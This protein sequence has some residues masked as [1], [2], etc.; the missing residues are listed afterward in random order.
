MMT[1]EELDEAKEYAS[2]YS[3]SRLSKALVHIDYLRVELKTA[4]ECINHRH[5]EISTLTSERNRVAAELD[6]ARAALSDVNEVCEYERERR[7]KAEA[8]QKGL[9]LQIQDLLNRVERAEERVGALEAV[10]D[11]V[12]RAL[13]C[14]GVVDA[15]R[16]IGVD[17]LARR[18]IGSP[19]PTHGLDGCSCNW[20][21]ND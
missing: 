14:Y 13:R 2:Y 18:L 4:V 19:C 15:S 17:R 8:A 21:T 11:A 6:E 20:R 7:E 1:K 16:A 5:A 10:I 3:D 12:D 9:H